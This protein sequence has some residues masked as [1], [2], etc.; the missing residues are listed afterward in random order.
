M[1]A[2]STTKHL[3]WSL[4]Q[5]YLTFLKK[6]LDETEMVTKLKDAGKLKVPAAEESMTQT[7]IEMHDT[8]IKILGDNNIV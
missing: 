5:P 8:V 6:H 2:S 1:N 3:T 7:I 4:I